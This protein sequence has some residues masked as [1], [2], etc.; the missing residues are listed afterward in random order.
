MNCSVWQ[1]KTQDPDP[2]RAI[3][4]L[5]S[6]IENRD[7]DALFFF[8][9]STYDL[10]KVGANLKRSFD[11]PIIGCTSSGQLGSGGYEKGGMSATGF[12][13]GH[14][15][16]VPHLIH[17]LSKFQDQVLQIASAIKGEKG[18]GRENAFGLLVIDGLS[19]MEERVASAIYQALENLPIIG[20]S[21]GDDLNFSQTHVYF[22]G[23]F[24]RD[25]AVL[26][27]CRARGRIVPFL[28]KHFVPGEQNL[29]ITESDPDRR[30]IQEF[31]GE[32]AAEVYA[33]A[34]GISIEELNPEV[35]SSHPLLMAVGVEYYVRSIAKALPDK[36][37]ALY[38]AIDTGLVVS[39]GRSVDPI[40]TLERTLEE[41]RR[42][43]GDPIA[44]LAC[45]C[46]LRRLEFESSGSDKQ[47]GEILARNQVFGFSTYGEQF[48]G[49]HVNQTLT[50]I[51]IGRAG[52]E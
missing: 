50:G 4:E 44:V 30:I 29:V 35:F 24:I 43:V 25:A 7:L 39:I 14:L 18:A 27:S 8:C 6:Q 40:L 41:V 11:C 48:N 23:N 52:A 34:L 20:G 3:L 16:V 22:D 1:G 5:R 9:S 12:S 42:D 33:R 38:C 46:I 47:V 13:G 15:R 2:E 26:A 19:M 36:S 28:V 17:P 10:A 51:V 21:A 31:N 49:L 37:L 45:D 32:P